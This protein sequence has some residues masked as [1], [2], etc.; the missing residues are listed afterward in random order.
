MYIYLDDNKI[1]VR[2]KSDYLDLKREKLYKNL[3]QTVNS[4]WNA[5]PH[6]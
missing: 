2:R 6:K 1:I 4:S 5:Q 3:S